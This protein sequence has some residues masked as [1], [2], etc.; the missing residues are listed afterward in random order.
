VKNNLKMKTLKN[1][2]AILCLAS[3]QLFAQN[4]EG[5]LD[6]KGR[7]A[8]A[9][10][11][12][13]QIENFPAIAKNA[14]N[15]K[16]NLIVSEN[17]LAG[18]TYNSR[19]ILTPNVVVAT[20]DLTPTSPPMTALSLNVTFYIGDGMDGIKYTTESFDVKGAGINEQKAYL[21]A[22]NRINAKDERLS[23]MVDKAKGKIVEYYNT[24]CDFIIKEA[25]T[26]ES[27]LKY[28]EALAK[29]SSI[30]E[31]C[32]DCYFKALE[33]SGPIYLKFIE[34]DCKKKLNEA[35]NV[36]AAN[37]SLE[38]AEQTAAILS[39][40][41][42]AAPCSKDIKPLTAKI[43]ARIKE[44]NNREWDFK[45]LEKDRINAWRDVGV[46]YGEG[47]PKTVVYNTRGWF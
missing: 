38:G 24:R 33:A 46:A 20:K 21:D 45:M 9:P 40:I 13:D 37:Q 29:L 22:I 17:G 5:K 42:P 30:P 32:K 39:T 41:D 2:I 28:D 25:K 8:I 34:R 14:L 7:I 36:W 18:S 35:S 47:Q 16:L 12:S 43:A 27:Q 31:A 23:K 19:F 44:I 15:N 26:L 10:Y 11:V 6:D 4:S 1:S 3:A